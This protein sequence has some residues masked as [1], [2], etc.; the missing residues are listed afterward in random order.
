M[1]VQATTG[2]V[3]STNLV[4]GKL[5]STSTD[6]DL[7][8]KLLMTQMQNQ[9]PLDPV[10]DKEMLAQ[11]AQFSALEQ[12]QNIN[13][14]L[15]ETKA[16]D[17]I[18]KYVIGRYENADGS[19]SY[20]EGR[21]EGVTMN[22]GEAYLTVGEYQI[23]MSNVEE[24]YE[25][26]SI[27]NSITDLVNGNSSVIGSLISSN[28][29]IGL[30]GQT[31]QAIIT[32]GDG[33]AVDFVEGKVTSIK[34]SNGI[35]VL[36]VNGKEVYPAEVIN[37]SE[38]KLLLGSNVTVGIEDEAGNMNYTSGTV[39]DIKFE[40]NAAF[41]LLDSGE[42]VPV[43]KINHITEANQIVG[44][45][46]EYGDIVGEATEVIIENGEVYLQIGDDRVLYTEVRDQFV[47]RETDETEETETDTDVETDTE[48]DTEVETE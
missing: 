12:A 9:N 30:V 3:N 37:I 19:Y 4:D 29:S 38:E 25:D 28:Q 31:V 35:P 34:F 14:T 46:V 39:A 18:G 2:I 33:N 48:T 21:V 42:K 11:L 47:N 20:T 26:Y 15:T 41:V 1:E 16:Y 7:F 43:N 40:D 22:N 23:K 24:V 5:Q 6:K 8:I 44:N 32:D 27:I 45:I 10:D 13:A 17:T 36:M